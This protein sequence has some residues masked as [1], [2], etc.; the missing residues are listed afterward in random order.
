MGQRKLGISTLSLTGAVVYFVVSGLVSGCAKEASLADASSLTSAT[1]PMAIPSGATSYSNL[2]QVTGWTSEADS[3]ISPNQPSTYNI[4]QSSAPV[5]M[6]LV[7]QGASGL[8]SGWIAKK[9]ITTPSTASHMLVR[10]SYT[11]NSVSGIQAWEVGRRYTNANGVTDNGQTQLSLKSNGQ[12]EFDIVPSSSGGWKDTGCRFPTFVAGTTY[13]EEL[14]YVDDS[15]GSL[16]LMYVSLNGTVC[17]IPS[18]LQSITGSSQGWAKNSAV[19]AFQP[20]ANPTGVEYKAVVT[21]NAWM[22]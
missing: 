11:F 3:S 2:E 6:T 20:D 16:S 7:T 5:E 21:M 17:D 10:V 19:L 1:F 13:N 22:W 12:L 4:T 15:T 8:Y 14:Y 18:S 9:S